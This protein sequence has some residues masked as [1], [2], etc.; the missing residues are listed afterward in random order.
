[1]KENTQQQ[2]DPSPQPDH[3]GRDDDSSGMLKRAVSEFISARVELTAIEAREA[4]EFT[5]RKLVLALAFVACIFITWIST[6][7][8]LVGIFGDWAEKQLANHIPHTHGW[9]IVLVALVII[10]AIVA[11]ILLMLL[12]K[13]PSAPLFELTRQEIKNDKVWVRRNK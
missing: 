13:K 9:V 10:H 6:M 1:M 5:V 12:K 3:S 8:C 11:S 7:A 4:A 2:Q